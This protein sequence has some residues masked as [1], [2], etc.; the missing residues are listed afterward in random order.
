MKAININGQIKTFNKIPNIWKDDNGTYI[1]IIDGQAYGF[2]DVA[3]PDFSGSYQ[4]LGD[5]YF[6]SEND[7]F[8]YPVVDVTFDKTIDELKESKIKQLKEV[9]NIK[10]S[11]TDWYV[12]RKS[13]KNID[14]PEN[15]IT[16]RDSL[17]SECANHEVFINALTEKITIIDYKF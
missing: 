16:E 10:L 6:D 12:V 9:Y 7:V 2:Y 17:R 1:N 3:I 15:I 14:M 13:E 11:N 8:T 4:Q 5:I